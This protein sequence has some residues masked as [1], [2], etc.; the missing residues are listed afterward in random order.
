MND[1]LRK[2]EAE[3][4]GSAFPSR[5]WERGEILSFSLSPCLPFSLSPLLLVS[6][7]F[8]A[9]ALAAQEAKDAPYTRTQ[10]V[11]YGRK[12]GMASLND[13][14]V[15]LVQRGIVD[16][17][18][19]YRHAADRPGFLGLLTRQGIDTSFVERLA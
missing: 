15:A 2:D 12:Y 1:E 3:L 19:A 6:L 13:V 18:E 5:P 10:D 7:S 8:L 17:R 4:R 9:P 16:S 14:L 11:I